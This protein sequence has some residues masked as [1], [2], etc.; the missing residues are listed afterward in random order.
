VTEIDSGGRRGRSRQLG[1]VTS[2]CMSWGYVGR[3]RASLF[4]ACGVGRPVG[5]G[6]G[7]HL[8]TEYRPS[9]VTNG[10]CRAWAELKSCAFGRDS[11]LRTKCT[12]IHFLFKKG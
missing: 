1:F 4:S 8:G 2:L 7:P 3:N 10:P 12:S 11:V 6:G 5:W 9:S